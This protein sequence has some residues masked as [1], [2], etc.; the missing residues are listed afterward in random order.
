MKKFKIIFSIIFLS[1]CTYS[2]FAKEIKLKIIET[3]DI[4]G[5]YFPHDFLNDISG[6]GSLARIETYIQ[7]QRDIY[8]KNLLLFDAGDLLQGQP[9]SYYYNF[10]DTVSPHLGARILNYMDYD[11]AV[12]GNHDIETGH[13]VYDRY[14]A[15]CKFPYL[16][17]NIINT[18]TGAPYLKPY[19]IF[20]REGIKIAVL[21]LLTPRIPYWIPQDL[22]SGLQFDDMQESAR[23]W[24]P[25]I[26][27]KEKA[28]III[29]LFHSGEKPKS[30]NVKFEE[31]ASFLIARDIPGFDIILLGHDHNA[32]CRTIT[33]KNGEKVLL[34]NPGSQGLNIARAEIIIEKKR[35]TLISKSISGALVNTSNCDIDSTFMAQFITAYDTIQKFSDSPVGTLTQTIS[36]RDS[37][38]GPSA[39]CD[40]INQLQLEISGADI[41]FTAPLFFD[42]EIKAGK[43]FLRDMF[44]LYKYENRLHTMLLT[45]K[46]I[47]GY[48]EHSY[49]LWT[50][51]MQS[52]EDDLL[53][54]DNQYTG[55]NKKLLYN[56]YNFD[57]AMGIKYTVDVTE[58]YGNKINIIS[59]SDGSSFDLD[60][61][62]KVA[63]NSYRANGD[64]GMLTKGAGIPKEKIKE[65][66]I[67][68]SD[69]DLRFNIMQYIHQKGTITPECKNEWKFIPEEWVAP[70]IER[71]RNDLFGNISI[72][73]KP[74]I[75]SH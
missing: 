46:E 30:G 41:S 4:H 34:L 10:I 71:N 67:K 8:G 58:P 13:S 33:N 24:L 1:F 22:W 75:N 23:K 69:N 56:S 55:T 48:L 36:T 60:K 53:L 14:F 40:F 50:N 70:A 66:I 20:V 12:P 2:L 21:G 37:Y 11:A 15:Q 63:I 47:K 29:G 3:S 52:S 25:I 61:T 74:S 9:T 39:F 54:F 27:E 32:L 26:R 5:N 43:I 62:Y 65:R 59:M 51:Q 49:S 18:S 45:G 38:F 72:T 35:N 44:K 64:D 19:H 17:A 6:N 16:G 28:D 73:N 31:N 42:T 57:S 68:T 7:Q